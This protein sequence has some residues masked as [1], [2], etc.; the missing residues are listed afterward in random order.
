MQNTPATEAALTALSAIAAAGYELDTGNSPDE[1]DW[2]VCFEVPGFCLTITRDEL[3]ICD[4]DG[5]RIE[6]LSDSDDPRAAAACSIVDCLFDREVEAQR[7]EAAERAADWAED[8]AT[9]NWCARN[10]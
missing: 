1:C 2:S 6:A 4:E 5:R 7:D 8:R 9:A 3:E 10:L